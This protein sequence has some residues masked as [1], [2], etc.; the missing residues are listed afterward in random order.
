MV[1]EGKPQRVRQTL[2]EAWGLKAV[3][4]RSDAYRHL[5]HAVCARCH[6]VS[7]D[8]KE[9]PAY[10]VPTPSFPDIVRRS[11]FSGEG[12]R[13]YLSSGHRNLGPNESMPNPRLNEY[14]IEVIVAYFESL[15]AGQ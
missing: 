13:L 10:R 2:A 7:P 1:A 14:Q 12:L 9:L 4:R 6:V 8:S 15:K 11:S 3:A 5:A